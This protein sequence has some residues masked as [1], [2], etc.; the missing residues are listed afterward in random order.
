MVITALLSECLILISVWFMSNVIYNPVTDIFMGR[1]WSFNIP[2]L[3]PAAKSIR[4][5]F[6]KI[7]LSYLYF[8]TI[9]GQ[10]DN[11]YEKLHWYL[12]IKL[13]KV[14]FSQWISLCDRKRI[15]EIY[16]SLPIDLLHSHV[17]YL[18][19]FSAR[20]HTWFKQQLLRKIATFCHK[21]LITI[22]CNWL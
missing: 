11:L 2:N 7:C 1:Y 10:A 22:P 13:R 5:R 20:F 17:I 4:P 19:I 12:F 21:P 16:W 15:T 9:W 8:I 14:A 3:S 18:V 6:F